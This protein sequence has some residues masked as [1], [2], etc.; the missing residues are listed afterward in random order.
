MN[1]IILA[2]A[3]CLCLAACA[4]ADGSMPRLGPAANLGSGPASF[5]GGYAGA[6]GGFSDLNTRST[7]F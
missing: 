7:S 6:N 5:N 2:I 1:K 4:N 3:A